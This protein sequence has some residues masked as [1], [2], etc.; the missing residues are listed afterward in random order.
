MITGT[1]RNEIDKLWQEFWT[2][3]ITNPLTVIEQISFL[4]FARLL[5]LREIREERVFTRQNRGREFLGT[6]FGP[7]TQHLRWKNL[8]HEGDAERMLTVVRD[9]LFPHM[10]KLA[11][12]ESALG[13]YLADAQL[14]ISKPGLLYSA[15]KMIDYLPLDQGDTKGDLYE[16]LLSKLTTAGINGQFR[17]P[18]HIIDMM[19]RM[20]D[21]KPTEVVG[22]P[23]CG[24]AGFLVQTMQHLLRTYSSEAGQFP[25]ED[26]HGQ[27]VRTDD[28][29]PVLVYTGDQLEPYRNHIQKEMF[30]GFEFDNTMLR[31]SAM[32]L[33][34][35]DLD[36]PNIHYQDTLSRGFRETRPNL[37][38]NHFDV[39]LANPP[40]KGSL[41]AEDVDPTLTGKVKT[42][43]T[44]LLFLVLMLR[45]LKTPGGRAG[46]I[47]P[48]GVLFG[49]SKAHVALRKILVEECEL[50]GMVS[51]PAGVFK[52]YAGVSTGVLFFVKGG[53]TEHVWFYDMT[54]DGYSLD[55]KRNK[56][57]ENDIPDILAQWTARDPQVQTDRKAKAFCVPVQEIRDND[58]DLSIN[59]YKAIEY[60][61]IEYEDPK[62]ILTKLR[63]LEDEIRRD[64][65]AL[66]E[67]LG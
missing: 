48:D 9:E 60:E 51:L 11:A 37:A 55:D 58:Y 65:D 6:R 2:G 23:A 40:F 39:I 61:E 46:V 66:E 28:G 1:L 8:R 67:M 59:R 47:V 33:M 50:Q 7:D 3:G 5:D 43:K 17:T 25:A 24:T 16:F 42:K 34:L 35:H 30:C 4:M 62:V 13:E 49:G 53:Q 57:D 27:P 21:P 38:E 45:M 29:D 26:E 18:R 32:N 52:P 19:V 20:V 22:D 44:E 31:I 41:D 56:I 63:T 12:N 15:V 36:Q 54:A 10:R 14:V 64:L